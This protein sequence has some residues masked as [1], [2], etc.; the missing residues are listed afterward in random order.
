MYSPQ[1]VHLA[2]QPEL[3]TLPEQPVILKRGVSGNFYVAS[4]CSICGARHIY[5]A[6]SLDQDPARFLT[7]RLVHCITTAPRGLVQL[8]LQEGPR[9]A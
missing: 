9:D 6:G 3:T 5:G 8:V 4:S 1:P 7:T 2:P